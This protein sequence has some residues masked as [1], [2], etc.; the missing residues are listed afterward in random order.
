MREFTTPSDPHPA[1]LSRLFCCS[2][3]LPRSS[4]ARAGECLTV[5][6][7]A[8]CLTSSLCCARQVPYSGIGAYAGLFAAP[9][10][11]E[12]EPEPK[13]PRPASPRRFRNPELAAQA[14]V[15]AESKAEKRALQCP[16]CLAFSVWL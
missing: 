3:Y 13:A 5:S 16:Q 9:G 6:A 1:R 15:D 12:Y 11:P 14:R 8:A 7:T 10:E 2:R 4:G